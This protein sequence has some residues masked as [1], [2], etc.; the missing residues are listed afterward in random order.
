MKIQVISKGETKGGVQTAQ[1]V[2]KHDGLSQTRHLKKVGGVFG[3]HYVDF[4]GQTYKID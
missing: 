3:N 1:I 2:I 4:W